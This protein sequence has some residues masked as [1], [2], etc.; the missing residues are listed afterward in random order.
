MEVLRTPRFLQLQLLTDAYFVSQRE[1][2]TRFNELCNP[3]REES[4]QPA[5][6]GQPETEDW[7]LKLIKVKGGT[8]GAAFVDMKMRAR[9]Y[10][11][12]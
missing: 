11:P 3:N 2:E 10:R 4:E 12:R 9:C 1:L 6:V 5:D 8:K 7:I